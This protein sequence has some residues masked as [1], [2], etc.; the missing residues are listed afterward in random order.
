MNFEAWV[1]MA[2]KNHRLYVKN[3][4]GNN[5]KSHEVMKKLRQVPLLQ[6]HLIVEE[7]KFVKEFA[8]TSLTDEPKIYKKMAHVF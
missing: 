6:A 5:R 4:A 7:L 2:K 8:L 1:R 3:N